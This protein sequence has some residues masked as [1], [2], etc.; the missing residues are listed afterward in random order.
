MLTIFCSS[1]LSEKSGEI[2]FFQTLVKK[3][4][5]RK[6]SNLINNYFELYL[7]IYLSFVTAFTDLLNNW[8]NV[9]FDESNLNITLYLKCHNDST[10]SC[11]SLKI[12]PWFPRL[13]KRKKTIF[14][15]IHSCANHVN[16]II[17]L[18]WEKSFLF[19]LFTHLKKCFFFRKYL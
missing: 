15:W 3:K 5:T 8:W 10:Y 6:I 4:E 18:V 9:D 11:D 1:F 7:Y 17:L 12:E 13:V 19:L 2:I 14:E 16:I